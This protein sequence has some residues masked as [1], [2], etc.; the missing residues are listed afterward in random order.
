MSLIS[1]AP[2]ARRGLVHG[3]LSA[4]ISNVRLALH[5]GDLVGCFICL[6]PPSCPV[7]PCSN[8]PFFQPGALRRVDGREGGRAKANLSEHLLGTGFYARHWQQRN[9]RWETPKDVLVEAQPTESSF[10]AAASKREAQP[11]EPTSE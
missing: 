2:E 8:L 4:K 11:P 9:E 1:H 6:S 10:R 7:S 5:P 3:G